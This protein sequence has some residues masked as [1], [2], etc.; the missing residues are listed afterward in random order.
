[1]PL[2]ITFTLSDND[3]KH[4]QAIVDQARDKAAESAKSAEIEA[5]ARELIEEARAGELPEFI[6][7]RVEQL[8]VVLR[9]VNDDEWRLTDDEKAAILNALAY[10]CE[11]DDIIPDNI[12]GLG[13]LDD[14]IYVEVVLDELSN[15]IHHYREF[16]TFREAEEARRKA[17]GE[18]TKVGREE[19]LADKRAA[20]HAKM[21]KRRSRG[22]VRMRLF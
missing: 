4:F 13:F 22:G 14:A 21:R 5:A 2:D 20:L 11:P 18:D 10:F 6:G 8:D 15:E 16:C 19:W 7:A 1:M 9:M 17:R 3:L 12:P